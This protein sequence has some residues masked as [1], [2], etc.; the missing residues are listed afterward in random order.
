MKISSNNNTG[1]FFFTMLYL[2]LDFARPQDFFPALGSVKPA[3]IVAII[4]IWYLL[5]NFNHIKI[6]ARQIKMMWIF[7]ALLAI[8]IPIAVNNFLAY[9]TVKIMVLYMPFILSVI[10]CVNSMRILKILLFVFISLMV[11]ISIYGYLHKGLG[12]GSYFNDENDLALYVNMWL[13]FCYYMFFCEKIWWKKVI[14]ACGMIMGVTTVVVGNSRGGFVGL[15]VTAV[16]LWFF[17]SHKISSFLIIFAFGLSLYSFSSPEYLQEMST[18][19]DTKESTASERI[20]SWQSAWDMFLDNPLGVGGNNFQVRFPEYQTNRF[21]RVMWG[22][23]AHSL[24]FTLIPETGVFGI[25]IYLMI[26]KYNIEDI[27]YI[28]QTTKNNKDPDAKYLFNMSLAMI[29]SLAG[30]FASATFLSVLYYAHYWYMT[31]LI[32]VTV[33]ITKQIIVCSKIEESE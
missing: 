22:R 29:A 9:T 5:S 32:I 27:I 19:T 20:K 26:L 18:V 14:Y 16:F 31:A 23:A 30:F 4:L 11:Y 25:L 7:I 3:M 8:F 15:I 2:V 1:W 10:I 13:P 24:W 17:S 6:N 33:N 12:S 21:Q 28:R